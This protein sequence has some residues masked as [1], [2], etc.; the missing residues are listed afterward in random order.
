MG[1]SHS[2]F[3]FVEARYRYTNVIYFMSAASYKLNRNHIVLES[4]KMTDL[5]DNIVGDRDN[6]D[7]DMIVFSERII[8]VLKK[9]QSWWT[10][11]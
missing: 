3:N 4:V 10:I 7:L 11:W 1:K 5:F 8:E 2:G 6:E 9:K